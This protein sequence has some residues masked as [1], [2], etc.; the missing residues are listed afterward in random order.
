VLGLIGELY[1]R[2]RPA[3]PGD[4]APRRIPLTRTV[5]AGEAGTRF[6]VPWP[7]GHLRLLTGMVRANRPWRLFT[8]LSKALAGVVAVA[9]FGVVND[10]IFQLA[11]A[12]GPARHAIVRSTPAG[13]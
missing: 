1:R 7:R 11:A 2:Q 6:V 10:T 8:G 3:A 13:G 5:P 12:L 4:P 9:A